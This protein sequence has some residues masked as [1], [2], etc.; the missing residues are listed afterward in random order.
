[1]PTTI[2]VVTPTYNRAQLLQRLY[3]SLAEGTTRPHQWIVVD[4]G[5][6]D[7]T[8]QV[9]NCLQSESEFQIDYL[10]QENQGQNC[11]MNLGFAHAT[12]ELVCKVD[13]DDWLLP[14]GL[15]TLQRVWESV[16][17]SRKRFFAGVST[18]CVSPDQQVIGDLFPSSPLDSTFVYMRFRLNVQGDKCEAVRRDLVGANSYPDGNGIRT[19]GSALL[20]ARFSNEHLL[21]R[22]VN[23]P[24]KI[25]EYRDDGLSK[26]HPWMRRLRNRRAFAMVSDEILKSDE[27][28]VR[29]RLRLILRLAATLSLHYISLRT[30]KQQL[31]Q[32]LSQR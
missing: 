29:A 26:S 10:S 27:L 9:I 11:A 21:F 3:L 16:P 31:I 18:L 8:W 7:N 15:E 20:F 17:P 12:G 1:M 28:S 5:S 32:L 22:H 24:T 23:A 13:S 30:F 2:S 4:D 6:T 14:V 25:K 19:P